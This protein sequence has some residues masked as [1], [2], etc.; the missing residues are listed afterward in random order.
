M[1]NPHHRKKH[2]THVRSFKQSHDRTVTETAK[3]RSSGKW[4]FAV[5]GAVAGFVVS[6][7]ATDGSILWM[8][9]LT[10][11]GGAAGYFIGNSIDK[12]KA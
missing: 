10:L 9:L 1:A 6:Y 5:A 8:A 12:Q 3:T 11:G 7:F 2:K 4:V